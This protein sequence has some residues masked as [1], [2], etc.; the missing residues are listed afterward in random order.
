M[1][2]PLS[3]G[4]RQLMAAS[5]HTG[6]LLLGR[7]DRLTPPR[8]QRVLVGGFADPRDYRK[9]QATN[10]RYF[11]ELCTLR[12]TESVL[13][14]GCGC[15][16]NAAVLT[17]YLDGT[18]TYEGFDIIPALVH[19]CNRHIAR[20][21]PRFHF[22]VADVF[23]KAYNPTGASRAA[24]YRFPY[25]DASFDFTFATSVFTHLLPEEVDNYLSETARVLRP[26]GR[27]MATFFLIN[28]ESTKGIVSGRSTLTFREQPG[29]CWS[30]DPEM[31][32]RAIAYHEGFVLDLY[33]RRGLRIW[34][35]IRYGS[36]PQRVDL[37]G[38]Q[39]VIIAEKA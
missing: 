17:R 24:D 19:W 30:V 15:G 14:I 21:Y 32:E 6:E 29:P 9:V 37:S 13:D 16:L 10:L 28:E 27:C 25:A 35:P 23:N 12:P 8:E 7:R 31:P 5:R 34:P 11:T 22:Q 3:C 18:A 39:D 33:T 4:L 26:G 36:W 1:F 20:R 38:Y 2:H